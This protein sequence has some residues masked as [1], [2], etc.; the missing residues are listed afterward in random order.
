M[1]N[2]QN[3]EAEK[4]LR[5]LEQNEPVPFNLGKK[6][7]KIHR[8]CNET[9]IY[10]QEAVQKLELEKM[11][12]PEDIVN[13]PPKSRRLIAK[14]ISL[15]ILR[16]P[17]KIALCHWFLWRRLSSK[18]TQVDYTDP[19]KKIIGNSDL[20]FFS[21][22]L[23]S[24]RLAATMEIQIIKEDIQNIAAKQKSGAEQTSS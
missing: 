12:N 20:L 7:Y 13:M 1:S 11:S 8:L 18:Y 9:S 19:I 22:N 23:T 24:V 3:I 15:I 4:V 16:R 21:Q 10:V 14:I 6:K 17:W 2:K 5:D